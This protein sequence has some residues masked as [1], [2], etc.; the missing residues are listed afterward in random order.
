MIPFLLSFLSPSGQT[1]L[2]GTSIFQDPKA[3]NQ[4]I[5]DKRVDWF[6]ND[7]FSA[8]IFHFEPLTY[9]EP[10]LHGYLSHF[11]P[12]FLFM[13]WGGKVAH[14]PHVGL[15]YLWEIPTILAGLF[16]LLKRKEKTPALLALSWV[17]LSVVP[18]SVTLNL[19]SSIRTAIMLPSLTLLSACG[20][21][22]LHQ[23]TNQNSQLRRSLT[24]LFPLIVALFL[25]H[26]LHMYFIHL[27]PTFSSQWYFGYRQI[28]Q[29]ADKMSPA[30]DRVIVSNK[31]DQPINFFTFFLKYDPQRYLR[32]DGGRKEG[33]Y[34]E[35]GN[36]FDKYFFENID[37]SRMREW[38]RVLFIGLPGE[39]LEDVRRLRTFTYLDGEVSAIFVEN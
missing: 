22:L 2:R 36:H 8:E 37:W 14:A 38:K 19:P 28:A 30:Y 25:V 23:T 6:R 21:F 24:F 20:L 1:R 34:E 35:S 39:F 29:E 12:R 9:F 5:A 11:D 4:M 26:Y 18:A 32:T 13:N 10:V 3:H 15:H 16:F 31:L 7:R 17:I 27:G 33:G